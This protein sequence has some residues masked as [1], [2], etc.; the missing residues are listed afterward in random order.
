MK[1]HE[2]QRWK[3][4]MKQFA[5]SN[6]D[7]LFT[8]NATGEYRIANIEEFLQQADNF[9]ETIP[10]LRLLE[11]NIKNFKYKNGKYILLTLN[12]EDED[13]LD[14]D[15]NKM[16]LMAFSLNILVFGYT[17][18]FKEESYKKIRLLIRTKFVK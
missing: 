6:E 12:S 14:T 11:G 7:V 10:S 15:G 4:E 9:Q 5:S 1:N 13:F 16:N 18:L 17:Y 8:H 2:Q 3:K